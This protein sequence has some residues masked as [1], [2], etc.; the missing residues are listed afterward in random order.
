MKLT[1]K[2]LLAGVLTLAFVAAPLA[3]IA[4]TEGTQKG[5]S[6]DRT[7]QGTTRT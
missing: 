1:I 3:A 7:E 4:C 6:G 2:P 5:D